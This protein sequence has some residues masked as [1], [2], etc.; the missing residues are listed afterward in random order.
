[1]SVTSF[2]DLLD[3]SICV[4]IGG[5]VTNTSWHYASRLQCTTAVH[6]DVVCLLVAMGMYYLHVPHVQVINC[7]HITVQHCGNWYG[8][9]KRVGSDNV[10]M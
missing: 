4:H 7:I 9:S 10:C 5:S 2:T 8:M 1:M 6:V 3:H